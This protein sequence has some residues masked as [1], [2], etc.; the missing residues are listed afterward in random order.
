MFPKEGGEKLTAGW[1]ATGRI[2]MSLVPPKGT[3]AEI[4][5]VYRR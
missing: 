3:E 2:A 5:E 4:G 1:R